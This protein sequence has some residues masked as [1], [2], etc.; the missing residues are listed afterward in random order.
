MERA[1]AEPL[2]QGPF[3]TKHKAVESKNQIQDWT[4]HQIKKIK[5][6]DRQIEDFER[7]SAKDIDRGWER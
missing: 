5:P 7:Q 2:W 1:G 4:D 6:E 3:A